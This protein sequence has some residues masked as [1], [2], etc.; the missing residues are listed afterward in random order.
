MGIIVTAAVCFIF[1]L[2]VKVENADVENAKLRELVKDLH[3]LAGDVLPERG[4]DYMTI[5]SV[6]LC[7]DCYSRRMPAIEQRMRGLGI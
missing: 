3:T 7:I 5:C 6:D 2:I 1:G 4:S